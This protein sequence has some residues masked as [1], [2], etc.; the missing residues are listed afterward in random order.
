M[1]SF[2]FVK[3]LIL[4]VLFIFSCLL[5]LCDCGNKSAHDHCAKLDINGKMECENC[6]PDLHKSPT[7]NSQTRAW[8]NERA[9][10]FRRDLSAH[11]GYTL[12]TEAVKI[13]DFVNEKCLNK[14]LPS[15]KD[16]IFWSDK[17]GQKNTEC[18]DA[19]GLTIGNSPLKSFNYIILNSRLIYPFAY[20]MLLDTIVHEM[21]HAI[22]SIQGYCAIH[23]FHFQRKTGHLVAELN[24]HLPEI[25]A[26]L[27]NWSG[28]RLDAKY[29][30]C[31][32]RPEDN[33]N[34]GWPRFDK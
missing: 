28:I 11:Q 12:Q 7:T 25:Q 16:C 2:L 14:M 23:G 5:V 19:I 27:Q 21:V 9:E 13:F 30:I 18:A 8:S 20:Q 22:D 6:L 3:S 15:G 32:E 29:I 17:V 33:R 26:I 31:P 4:F 1:C 10:T 34:Q 24:K